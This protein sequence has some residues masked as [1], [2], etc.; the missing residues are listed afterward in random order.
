MSAASPFPWHALAP[1]GRREAELQKLARRAAASVARLDA[2]AEALGSILNARVRIAPRGCKAYAETRP[3]QGGVA[4]VANVAGG[5][6]EGDVMIEVEASLARALASRVLKRPAAVLVD[7]SKGPGPSTAGVVAAV[8]TAAVRGAHAGLPV[9][10]S[11][12]GPSGAAP[13]QR[14]LAATLH[15]A[16]DDD[17]H[18]ARI[19]WPESIGLGGAAPPWDQEALASLGLLPLEL[20]IVA[21]ASATSAAEVAALRVGDAWVPSPWP[22]AK[23]GTGPVWLAAPAGETAICAALVEP[24]KL[25][26]RGEPA[27]LAWIPEESPMTEHATVEALGDAPVVVRVEIGTAQM[28]ARA[29]SELRPGDV[30]ALGRKLGEPVVLRAGGVEIA[31]GELV[32][33]EGEVG[34]RILE[35][36]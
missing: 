15:V 29:W 31:R 4:V 12:A 8:L 30:V 36:T 18:L 34:V 27:S 19:V 17:V 21:A 6:P 10:V 20:A 35:R 22:L 2:I 24:G 28:T 1:V 14:A 26:L 33:I 9:R 5:G 16:V 11:A 23:N 13:P 3:I 32:Q 25:V 7:P